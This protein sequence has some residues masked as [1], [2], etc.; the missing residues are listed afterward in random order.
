MT[1]KTIVDIAVLAEDL[2][3][4]Y[5]IDEEIH[6]FDLIPKTPVLSVQ[7]FIRLFYSNGL[8]N[9]FCIN[10]NNGALTGTKQTGFIYSSCCTNELKSEPLINYISFKCQSLM[11]EDDDYD[12]SLKFNLKDTIFSA[13]SDSETGLGCNPCFWTAC[14]RIELTDQLLKLCFLYNICNVCCSLTFIEALES[15]VS[16]NN[17]NLFENSIV[18]FRV[19]VVFTNDNECIKD[20]VVRFN[21]FVDLDT[22]KGI[23]P[24]HLMVKLANNPCKQIK[25]CK[26]PRGHINQLNFIYSEYYNKNNLV[27][28]SDHWDLK[29]GY[30]CSKQICILKKMLVCKD[31]KNME[32]NIV[33]RIRIK[34]LENYYHCFNKNGYVD[35]NKLCVEILCPTPDC[36]EI[37]DTINL[38]IYDEDNA[39]KLDTNGV[40]V[41][42]EYKNKDCLLPISVNTIFK[43]LCGDPYFSFDDI[44][45]NPLLLT[46]CKIC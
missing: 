45:C 38:A 42:S 29:C 39:G 32:H 21:Y 35:Q 31:T 13:Y 27:G 37:G 8:N 40:V 22:G 5:K 20:V 1:N 43:K 14:S 28:L 41:K 46:V 26:V 16:D 23:I 30:Y 18:K 24:D 9:K 44:I 25:N 3:E 33:F 34:V 15:I 11:R 19:S 17:I 4:P 10:N 36:F 6:I 2:N 12:D 7:N